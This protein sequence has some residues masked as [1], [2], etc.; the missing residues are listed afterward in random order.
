MKSET[1]KYVETC[2]VEQYKF[3]NHSIRRV[4][5]G[6]VLALLRERNDL[7]AALQG[8]VADA[9]T[10]APDE[11]CRVIG[12][13]RYTRA[14]KS[15]AIATDCTEPETETALAVMD[16]PPKGTVNER[17][18]ASCEALAEI[19]KEELKEIG[20]C[21]HSVGICCCGIARELEAALELIAGT[22]K[23]QTTGH[24]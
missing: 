6:D 10:A 18:L 21:D 2:A 4:S 15:L 12:S 11:S 13:E 20:G 22:K 17:L 19:V 24:A 7:L 8:M 3:G 9:A 16:R 14:L 1:L 5:S 23:N